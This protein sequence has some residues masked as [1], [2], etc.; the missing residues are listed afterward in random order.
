MKSFLA[1]TGSGFVLNQIL[2]P[3]SPLV[4]ALISLAT[5]GVVRLTQA[6]INRRKRRKAAAHA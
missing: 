5:A 1:E 2:T 6:I 4:N 3:Q